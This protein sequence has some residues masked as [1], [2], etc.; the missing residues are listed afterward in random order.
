MS[1]VALGISFLVGDGFSIFVLIAFFEDEA[2][3]C[4]FDFLI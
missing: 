4:K 2:I 3:F 1:L